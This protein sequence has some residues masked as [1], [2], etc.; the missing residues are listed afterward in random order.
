MRKI[1]LTSI[2]LFLSLTSFAQT[3][4]HNQH[5]NISNMMNINLVESVAPSP[6]GNYVAYDVK[7]FK[8]SPQG[9]VTH[10]QIYLYNQKTQKNFQLTHQGMLNTNPRWSPDGKWLAFLSQKNG[11][12]NIWVISLHTSKAYQITRS[13]T[14]ID[15][16]RWRP[17]AQ[18][19]AFT[20][21]NPEPD[22][23][24]ITHPVVFSNLH[25]HCSNLWLVNL[26]DHK[27]VK[28]NPHKLTNF[29]KEKICHVIRGF[30][31]SPNNNEIAFSH[32]PF[33]HDAITEYG[34]IATINVNTK[35]M[36]NLSQGEIVEHDPIYSHDG[37]MIAFFGLTGIYVIPVQSGH[38]REL[39]QTYDQMPLALIGWS[40]N[41]KDI[42]AIGSFH[43]YSAVYQL[44]ANGDKA[45]I[46]SP[47][48]QY[49]TNIFLNRDAT[50]FGF[51]MENSNSAEEAYIS[52]L[53]PFKPQRISFVNKNASKLPIGKTEVIHWK[54]QGGLEIEGLLTYPIN[55]RKGKRYPL[56]VEVH[57][58]PAGVFVQ[59]YLGRRSVFPV[60]IF[61]DKGYAY[62]RPNVR[63][64]SGYGMQFRK[65]SNN[66]WGGGDFHDLMTGVQKVINMGVADKN[67]IGI[68]GWSYGG[69]MVMW[70]ISQTHLFKAAVLGGGI[71]DL[72]SY[73]GTNDLP[74]FLPKSLG[75]YFWNNSSL[76]LSRS[77]IM[78]VKNVQTPLL[79]QYGQQDYRVPF[80]QGMEFYRALKTRGIDTKFLL[81]PNTFHAIKQPQLIQDAAR[82]DL[83]WMDKYLLSA[84][85]Q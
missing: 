77:P 60:Q 41:N 59:R 14:N 26:N 78:F 19:I 85:L 16:F 12:N 57:G 73:A 21:E 58:G 8:K 45:I 83:A 2:F 55:F 82:Q 64:S 35:K 54:S 80:S 15:D 63:G 71:S 23:S 10:Q 81:Y 17:D 68:Q 11:I 48:N 66:D 20:A 47:K 40:A 24:Q 38:A 51:V 62:F 22:L 76:Y 74:N 67:R 18:S 72:I 52:S 46:I 27:K 44:P 39:A 61:S 28:G 42:Y 33:G 34:H 9:L 53:Q 75:G 29:N 56:I 6:N 37:K 69:Y 4:N 31:W 3:Q 32:L 13:Q 30:N 36:R 70:A 5:W 50:L 65:L 25:V 7:H 1:T 79:L 43:T 49:I 84:S